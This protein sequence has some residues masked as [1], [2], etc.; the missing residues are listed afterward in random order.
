MVK[1]AAVN[2]SPRYVVYIG[3]MAYKTKTFDSYSEALEYYNSNPARNKTLVDT[4]PHKGGKQ[5]G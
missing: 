2:E 1:L 3:K 4:Q 5:D